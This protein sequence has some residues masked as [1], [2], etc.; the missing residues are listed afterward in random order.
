MWTFSFTVFLS[1]FQLL[2]TAPFHITDLGGSTLQ[3]G[4]FLGLL[5]VSSA[6]FAPLTGA[7]GDRI[8]HRRVLLMASAAIALITVA[9]AVLESVPL[10]LGLAFVQGFFWSG[11]LSSSNAYLLTIIPRSRRAEGLGYAGMA[12]V[13]AL[14]V[15]PTVG[16]QIYRAGWF[17][18]A[19][20]CLAL[21]VAV[22]FIA[23]FLQSHRPDGPHPPLTLRSIVEPRV[24][25]LA[26]TLFLFSFGY[27]GLTS[28]SAL[29][30]DAAGVTPRG[31]YLTTLAAAILLARP[32]LGHLGDRY[33]YA[34]VFVPC[35]VLVAIA[36]AIL[37]A[38]P[39]RTGMVLSALTFG[40]GFGLAYPAF[41]AYVMEHVSDA[42][43]G[44]AFGTMIA[45]FDTG[46]GT[47]STTMGW[48][49][50]EW[51]YAVAFGTAAL[52]AACAAPYFLAVDRR[53]AR[54]ETKAA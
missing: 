18:L 30:A 4:M 46:I 10:I 25:V 53:L 51:G 13:F 48:L 37:A 52:L 39:G 5:T 32:T 54:M 23:F 2:P 29:Y 50:Q 9:Y 24:I 20:T 33:G 38:T 43:R 34:R 6:I 26:G 21:N 35:I 44:A 19:M 7:I 45:A 36:L 1:V 31:L 3:A 40:V 22:F 12:S 14:G 15:A 41:T 49:I 42:R 17:W 47:G 27:G 28:F 16:F 8:G 11:M